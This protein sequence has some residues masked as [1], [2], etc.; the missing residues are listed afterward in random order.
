MRFLSCFVR[1]VQSSARM[2]PV[3]PVSQ[4][5]LPLKPEAPREIKA[6]VRICAVLIFILKFSP[7]AKTAGS[8]ILM[9]G[10]RDSF[11]AVCPSLLHGCPITFVQLLPS[12]LTP[13][14]LYLLPEPTEEIGKLLLL[15]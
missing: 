13:L 8:G 9:V 1:L 12:A 3:L 15:N 5:E 4:L 2:A 6:S 14:T 11:P 7:D 10:C